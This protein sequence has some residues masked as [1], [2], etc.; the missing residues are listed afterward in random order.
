MTAAVAAIHAAGWAHD[1]LTLKNFLVGPRG[2]P[3][4]IDF[5]RAKRTN[6]PCE[7]NEGGKAVK[8]EAWQGDVIC[9]ASLMCVPPNHDVSSCASLIQL[10]LSVKLCCGPNVKTTDTAHLVSLACSHPT[11]SL[12]RIEGAYEFAQYIINTRPG[13]TSSLA[14]RRG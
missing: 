13:M 14:P 7:I 2:A 11:T 4:M 5:G 1:D 10:A 3:I 6:A 12:R 8:M 9:L